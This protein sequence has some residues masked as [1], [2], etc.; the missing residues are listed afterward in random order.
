M[1]IK[2]DVHDKKLVD[3][4]VAAMQAALK[5]AHAPAAVAKRIAVVAMHE[6]NRGRVAA[7]RRYPFKGICEQSGRPLSDV[8]AV[9]DELE[10]HLG[11]AGRVRWVCQKANNSGKRS[12]G[13]C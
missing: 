12:C 2:M 1:T 9:L 11:Y 4:A 5:A 10:P 6:R 13:D 3:R 7:I 8:D